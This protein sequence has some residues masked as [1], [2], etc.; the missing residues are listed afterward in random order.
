[1]ALLGVKRERL[2]TGFFDGNCLHYDAVGQTLY[3]FLPDDGVFFYLVT[4][5][6]ISDI[7]L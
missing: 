1:M 4:T 5:S 2:V 7:S 6:W 3:V